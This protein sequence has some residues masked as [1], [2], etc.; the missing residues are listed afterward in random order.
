MFQNF[1]NPYEQKE[2]TDNPK[3]AKTTIL[4]AGGGE[5]PIYSGFGNTNTNWIHG[6]VSGVNETKEN[7]KFTSDSTIL[8][9]HLQQAKQVI[10]LKTG[11]LW[12]FS[13]SNKILGT[14]RTES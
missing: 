1:T 13:H 9:R 10:R 2:S 4:P 11:D 6:S 3:E 8:Q 7:Y 12:S 5:V 14:T